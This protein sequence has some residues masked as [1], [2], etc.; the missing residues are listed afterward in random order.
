MWVKY[1]ANLSF[2]SYSFDQL[3]CL[4]RHRSDRIE[5]IT[6]ILQLYVGT[7]NFHNFTAKNA[8]DDVRK[9]VKS[10]GTSKPFIDWGIEYLDAR[11]HS[12]SY[13][14]IK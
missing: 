8:N 1:N 4:E 14:S 2:R 5:L 12:Q 3:E 13:Y 6:Y 11:I 9:A 7:H 10:M